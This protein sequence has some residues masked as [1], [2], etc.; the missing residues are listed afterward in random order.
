M[1]KKHQDSAR[2]KT[3]QN[4]YLLW[5]ILSLIILIVVVTLILTWPTQERVDYSVYN[6][7][8]FQQTTGGW[9]TI[10]ERDGIPFEIPFYYHP[11]EIENVH[12]QDTVIPLMRDVIQTQSP[13]RQ[14]IL[15]VHPDAGSLPVL[16]GVNIAR[17]TGDFYERATRS[18]L[19]LTPQEAQEREGEFSNPI[20]SCE[21]ANF[22]N[23]VIHIRGNATANSVQ[24]V[25]DFCIEV[26]GVDREGLLMTADLM[27]YRLLG[28]MR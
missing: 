14:F 1:A 17:V 11:L 15:T 9:Q 6:R 22:Q 8:E 2:Q 3:K 18:A 28:I 12:I 16:A 5:G 20:I 10:V 7:F 13:P 27:A 21:D 24:F 25:D 26:A 4:P 23:V 19:F